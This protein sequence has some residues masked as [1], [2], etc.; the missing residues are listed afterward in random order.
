MKV[1]HCRNSGCD[2]YI[3]RPSIFGNP[4]KE[5]ID[6][7]RDEVIKKY[8]TW[9]YNSPDAEEVRQA[10]MKLP[11]DSVIGCW[12]KPKPCH[13]DIIKQFREQELGFDV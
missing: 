4:F 6:G 1:V 8:E 5:D 11:M 3:G 9:L 2:V 7:T 13:G 10:I 12:C